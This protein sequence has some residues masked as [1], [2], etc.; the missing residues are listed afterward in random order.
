MK[1]TPI[2]RVHMR[3]CKRQTIDERARLQDAAS[4]FLAVFVCL[5]CLG[6][7]GAALVHWWLS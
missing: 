4:E 3:D 6:F 7:G 1:H 2:H 5:I